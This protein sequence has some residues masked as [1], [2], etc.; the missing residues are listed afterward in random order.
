MNRFDQVVEDCKCES[1]SFHVFL[2]NNALV[3][4][5]NDFDQ[6]L[7]IDENEVLDYQG[8]NCS[9]DS[10]RDF[11]DIGINML[12]R[13]PEQGV[14]LGVVESLLPQIYENYKAQEG[15]NPDFEERWEN[16][17]KSW[18]ATYD[19]SRAVQNNQNVAVISSFF[20][21]DGESGCES[22]ADLA[23]YGCGFGFIKGWFISCF[24]R[25]CA[26]ENDHF[27]SHHVVCPP[28]MNYDEFE[29]LVFDWA[30][31]H[32]H[33]T[34]VIWSAEKKTAVLYGTTK[35]GEKP[36]KQWD[37]F[38]EFTSYMDSKAFRTFAKRKKRKMRIAGDKTYK[39]VMPIQFSN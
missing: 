18:T 22:A 5:K 7:A 19:L 23:Q 2:K 1:F 12:F 3:M 27:E 37:V 8:W 13:L 28:A 36:L 20:L 16:Y 17:V 38:D 25:S 9:D 14:A 31:A 34:I 4:I 10:V 29:V 21:P 11:N 26:G 33:H 24:G 30:T 35:P 6:L 32:N 39:S 15:D